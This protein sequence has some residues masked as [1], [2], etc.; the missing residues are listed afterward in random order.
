MHDHPALPGGEIVA[1]RHRPIEQ[2]VDMSGGLQP[3]GE[4]TY[5]DDVTSLSVLTS[6][7]LPPVR[8]RWPSGSPSRWQN[9]ADLVFYFLLFIGFLCF[10]FLWFFDFSK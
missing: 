4:T 6:M 5:R 1:E 7:L 9:I 10:L 3:T 8:P 2:G